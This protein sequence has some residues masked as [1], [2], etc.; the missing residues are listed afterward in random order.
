MRTNRYDSHN[1]VLIILSPVIVC[2]DVFPQTLSSAYFSAEFC[3]IQ[4]F[5]IEQ[6]GIS[7]GSQAQLTIPAKHIS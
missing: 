5:L 6:I 4:S 1:P 7:S 2:G 3:D